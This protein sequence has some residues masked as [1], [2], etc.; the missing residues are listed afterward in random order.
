MG[1]RLDDSMKDWHAR[2]GV[3]ALTDAEGLALFDAT[4]ARDEIVLM[5]A[6]LDLAALRAQAV[7]PALLRGLVPTSTR[8]VA[9]A[10]G[11][12]NPALAGLAGLSP[13]E[14]LDTLVDLVRE[15]A[16][17]VLGHENTHPIDRSAAF[18]DLGFDSLISV[19]FRN[20]LGAATGLRLPATL[21]FDY[22]AVPPLARYLHDEL[23]DVLLRGA[24][25]EAVT[26]PAT[27]LNDPIA[28]VGMACRYPGGVGSPEQLWQLVVD[29]ADAVGPFPTDRG[30][31]MD[32]SLGPV[33]H[34][35]F[36]YDVADFDAGFFG[37]APREALAMDPQQRLLLET[38][39]ETFESAGIDPVTL[40]GS[41]TGVF[42][43]VMYH[44]YTALVQ[45]DEELA[46]Y[47]ATGGSASVASGRIAY[48]FGL[49]G[50]AVT[51]DTA[52]S[53]SLV[54]LHLAAQALRAGECTMALAGGVTVMAMPGPFAE[55]ARQGGLAADGR[56]KAFGA[57]AD[58]TGWSEGV[59]VLLVERLADAQRNGHPVLAVVRGS[60]TNQDGASNGLTAPNGP[61]Q[62]RVIRQALANAGLSTADVDLVEA[63]G[64]GTTLGDPIE[65]QALLA[66]YGNGRPADRPLRLG[67]LKSNI[68]HTQ[69]AAGVGGIIKMVQAMRH[70]IM[71]RTLHAD[72]PTPHVDWSAGAVELLTE[73]QAWPESDRPRRAAV[74]SFGFSGT[75]A[76][77]ILE[78]ASAT[79][80]VH[81]APAAPNSSPQTVALPIS[82]RSPEALLA[83]ADRLRSLV[84]GDAEVDLADLAGALATTRAAHDYRAVVIG[85]D[86]AEIVSGLVDL[87]S[88]SSSPGLVRGAGRARAGKT[89]FVFPGQGSQWVG[90]GQELLEHSPVF[91]ARMAECA[92]ALDALSGWSLLD[93]VRG[94]EGAPPLERTDVLQPVWFAML[95][96]LAEVW[97]AHGVRPDA[98]VGHSQ[99]ELAAA[100]VSGALSLADAARVAVLRSKLIA[101][102]LSGRSGMVSV[103]LSADA[104][105]G[106]LESLESD[107]EIGGLNGPELTSVSGAPAGLEQLIRACAEQGIRTRRIGI[108]YASHSAHV[109]PLE[110]ELA[111][112]L[113]GLAPRPTTVPMFSTVTGAVIDGGELGA[114][115]WYRNLRQTVLFE[116]ALRAL[117]EAEFRFFV[118]VSPHPL[119][120][121][122]IGQLDADLVAVGTLRRG[123][124]GMR[125]L[126]T[127]LAEFQ[128]RGCAVDWR[129]T[130]PAT[131]R[132][133][134][135][136]TYAFQHRRH[137]PQGRVR[138]A[139]ASDHGATATSHPVLSAAVTLPNSG[140]LLFTGRL[141]VDDQP[142]LADHRV[143][144]LVLVPGAALVELVVRAADQVGCP[145]LGEL[146]LEAPLLLD[147]AV[148]LRVSVGEPDEA[149]RRVVT[150][151]SRPEEARGD[152]AWT[153]HATASARPDA[154]EPAFEL[155]QWPP[156]DATALDVAELYQNLA[157]AGL[158]YGPAFR[159]LRAAW[160]R[161]D[162]IF[163]EVAL[164]DELATDTFILHPAL[165]DAAL[166]SAAFAAVSTQ[167]DQ[168]YVPF[169]WREVSLHAARARAVRVRI[170]QTDDGFAVQLADSAG[171]PVAT[172]GSVA[173][174]PISTERLTPRVA[175]IDSMY[176]MEWTEQA[177]PRAVDRVDAWLLLGD[178]R[179]P[180]AATLRRDGAEVRCVASLS[181]IE[182]VPETVLVPIADAADPVAHTHETVGR[183]TE[184]VR[185][186]LADARFGRSRLAVLTRAG[187][188]TCA[189]VRGFVRSAQAEHPG[190]FVLVDLDEVSGESM[191]AALAAGQSEVR[192]RAGVLTVPRLVPA[193]V[194][195]RSG[196][197][198]DTAGTVLVTGALGALGT[199][200]ARHLVTAHGVRRLLLTS[201]Q[202][203]AARG[204]AELRAE[205]AGLG[206]EVRIVACD[207]ADR[208]SVRDLLDGETLIGVVH[209]AGVLDDGVVTA[210]T[211]ERV[212][213]VLRPKVDA[214]W[215]LHELTAGMPLTAFVLFS[216]ASGVFQT[217]GQA[218]YAAANA[219]LDEL[220]R[221]RVAAGLPALSLAWGRWDA[222]MW[223]TG[224]DS[225]AD[226][227]SVPDGLRLFDAAATV[228]AAVLM[229]MRLPV[230][231][232][233]VPPLLRAV[234][235]GAGRRVAAGDG[236]GS[237][238]LTR[239]LSRMTPERQL[240]DLA[241]LVVAEV[242]AVLGHS[243]SDAVETELSFRD[244][245]FDS[246]AAVDLRNRLAA[247]TGLT[248]PP[249]L[250]FDHPNAMALAEQLCR[251][252]GL[253]AVDASAELAAHLELLEEL[254]RQQQNAGVEHPKIRLRLRALATDTADEAGPVLADLTTASDDELFDLLDDN[255]GT[256]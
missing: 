110:A 114:G 107:L 52:C 46:G 219:F 226:S 38:T 102:R 170:S 157:V 185:L 47:L 9:A 37:I 28:I 71:P 186:W 255:L 154:E 53:S 205:L 155:A 161:G 251:E 97:R 172:V 48:T 66:T 235:R 26:R 117:A 234:V 212:S 175:P 109:E 131:I 30:W 169:A 144:G 231:D 238:A 113:A 111:D 86:R 88:G 223:R 67:S 103:E 45:G 20:R 166:H 55:F 41:R 59:G 84:A 252:L 160:R 42:T 165:L 159:G 137:W 167:A 254:L 133:I 121:S 224:H 72:E 104:T 54:A 10:G 180:V 105:R 36:L 194:G 39:W 17:A 162:E 11:P 5:P 22:P 229:P 7:V 176:R 32:Q 68:G 182:A 21:V 211:P 191:S 29:G 95:V 92:A 196:F 13:E 89:V 171:V 195:E 116:P 57:D 153:L 50:P 16:A 253:G 69:A 210:M 158:E 227:L 149:G 188:L 135:L 91:A 220:A 206:A 148:Q 134:S 27:A 173:V 18:A 90:M 232:G 70:G 127:S 230:F 43:G 146:T 207:L 256:V 63:H 34:G 123:D 49:E 221:H 203:A 64:T 98:V 74:S 198:W 208:A 209:A 108:D 145:R 25:S 200:V 62:Q 240:D 222:G 189:A 15:H 80:P 122:G 239:R 96:S 79:Q 83:Q 132:P 99:G 150:V 126:L 243:S 93:V 61:A 87:A 151:Y 101:D 3:S 119:L 138:L 197:G 181:D 139:D 40:H 125:R 204:A 19:E 168:A 217:P 124:G 249:T 237:D 201:R 136:P 94:V 4:L 100:C 187:S 128:V 179:D 214:A 35:G 215:H 31:R 156:V 233:P 202:G 246:L 6:R 192:G 44:D 75:N 142:W 236:A 60:A 199:E 82:A 51:V 8:R 228:D 140:A 147:G 76:H 1:T 85:D 14:K 164:A 248:L 24:A 184:V 56:C 218:N 244:L 241:R 78:Q 250:V 23:S 120:L 58:G 163:A 129:S 225:S 141:S 2:S 106:L 152:E 115:Y 12:K 242:A 190:R 81:A 112:L 130:L 247:R 143:G 174:R 213:K 178:D 118:E 73:A 177:Q 65:A 193:T 245:G 183:I 77:V 33:R 216:S